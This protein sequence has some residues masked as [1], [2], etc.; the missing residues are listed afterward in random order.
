MTLWRGVGG[1]V[2][3]K[4]SSSILQASFKYELNL[5]LSQLPSPDESLVINNVVFVCELALLF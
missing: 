1:E 5:N 4:H 2:G 3:S